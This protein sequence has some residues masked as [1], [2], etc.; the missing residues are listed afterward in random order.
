MDHVAADE[1][2]NPQPR[3]LAG[4]VL[5]LARLFS[6]DVQEGADPAL[7][8]QLLVRLAFSVA[9]RFGDLTGLADLF[10]QGHLSEQILHLLLGRHAF[11][12][13][14]QV[15][16]DAEDLLAEF[17]WR[18]HVPPG[19]LALEKSVIRRVPVSAHDV[20]DLA[21]LQHLFQQSRLQFVF[22]AG[23]PDQFVHGSRP[24][25]RVIVEFWKW[26]RRRGNREDEAFPISHLL[27][28][29][30]TDV[31]MSGGL[32]QKIPTPSGPRYSEPVFYS[33][34]EYSGTGC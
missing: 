31:R 33:M 16:D 1:Q 6:Q 3:L 21:L 7:A 5:K 8:D 22:D 11:L 27:P 29:C 12:S 30:S 34:S 26:T 9:A 13:L 20:R 4:D 25:K 14:A 2:R 18:L 15:S 32:R 17:G 24:R 19:C 23:D 10:G 28:I